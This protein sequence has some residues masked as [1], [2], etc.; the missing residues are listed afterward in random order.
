VETVESIRDLDAIAAVDGV[1]GVFIGPRDLSAAMGY[2][3]NAAHSEVQQAIEDA[4]ARIGS[5]GKAAGILI[6][7]QALAWRYLELGAV[8]VA[9]G[10][11][12]NLLAPLASAFKADL[13]PAA[14]PKP[15]AAY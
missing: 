10:T 3:G 14:A 9:V 2:T 6:Q 15:D 4:I 7:D 13:A 5:A 12:G 1:D 8:F 11:D